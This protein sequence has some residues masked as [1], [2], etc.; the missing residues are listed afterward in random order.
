MTIVKKSL[1]AVA[2]FIA[3]QGN[4]AAQVTQAT[5][6]PDADFKL[7]KE[8]YQKEQFSLAYPLF[9]NIASYSQ[10]N[11]KLPISTQLEAKYYT[12]VTGLRMNESTA[13][14][15]AK[16]FI[17]TEHNAPRI[18]M[19][20]YHLGEYYFNQQNYSEA[21]AMYDMAGIENLSNRE[22]AEMKFHQAYS[23]FTLQ[24]FDKAKPLFNSIRQIP[25]DPNYY[26]A[27]YY[28]GFISFYEKNY[29]V[30]L[31]SFR[32]VEN[33]P[34]YQKIVPYYIAEILYF[35]G[36]KDK[37]IQYGEE[38]LATGGQYY[39]LNLRQL[40]GHAYFE[41]KNYSK[42]LPYLEQYYTTSDKVRREDLYELSYAYYESNE[43]YKSNCR[44]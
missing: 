32:T 16:E 37:A 10:P 4:V 28:Y 12:I 27:N 3:I 43:L 22:I 14:A 9:K 1:G 15:S 19:L 42:A 44:F 21:L 7:A 18:E 23:Y 34:T 26:D 20:S 41:K 39:D 8:L 40:L 5:V 17:A 36:E 6:D 35:N 11:S 33:Q 30:A 25:S 13:E 31:E 38:K 29:R 24:E 2:L